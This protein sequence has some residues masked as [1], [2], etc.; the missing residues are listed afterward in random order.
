MTKNDK[1][2]GACVADALALSFAVAAFILEIHLLV[3]M[4]EE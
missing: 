3:M 2:N 1:Q 4:I